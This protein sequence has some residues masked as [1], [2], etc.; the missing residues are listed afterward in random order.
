MINTDPATQ[1][2]AA[3]GSS[4]TWLRGGTSP[5]L[6]RTTFDFTING[7]GWASL[8]DGR[9]IPGGWELT[10]ISVPA[11]SAIRARGFVMGGRVT[12]AFVEST[13]R[14]IV[15][16][17]D[18]GFRSNRFG[19]NV[20]GSAGQVVIVEGATNLADWIALATNALG[21]GSVYFS[22]PASQ[23]LPGRSYRVR[24]Q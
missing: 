19:F 2:L 16:A 12:S 6:W 13:T 5:E 20:S 21:S 9:R 7:T 17:T 1:S 24:L 15:F 3:N 22:D 8:G 23:N 18:S 14:P 11:N 4:I 10:S